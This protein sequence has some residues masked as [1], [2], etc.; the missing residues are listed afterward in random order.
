MKTSSLLK[1][2]QGITFK[3]Q[4]KDYTHLLSTA[5]VG[6]GRIIVQMSG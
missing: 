3:K 6:S 5:D 4:L 1:Q 2:T